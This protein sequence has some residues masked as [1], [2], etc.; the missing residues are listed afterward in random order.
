[1]VEELG[2][3]KC[4]AVVTGANGGM[5]FAVDFFACGGSL[6]KPRRR[7]GGRKDLGFTLGVL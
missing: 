5:G 2:K 3:R 7:K 1:M 4:R 6:A